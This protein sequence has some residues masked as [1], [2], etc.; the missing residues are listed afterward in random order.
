[1]QRP[2]LKPPAVPA[3]SLGAQLQS[4]L[5]RYP[6]HVLIPRGNSLQ[7]RQLQL[8]KNDQLDMKRASLTSTSASAQRDPRALKPAV[9]PLARAAP[10][11]P[12]GWLWS[13]R[14]HSSPRVEQRRGASLLPCAVQLVNARVDPL[15]RSGPRVSREETL[16]LFLHRTRYDCSFP[17]TAGVLGLCRAPLEREQVSGLTHTYCRQTCNVLYIYIYKRYII[18]A[19]YLSCDI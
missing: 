6:L 1:M 14:E 13:W 10:R 3:L 7:S 11:V 4:L 16:T 8:L 12:R 17:L 2:N 15:D 9:E 19:F 5:H 18:P